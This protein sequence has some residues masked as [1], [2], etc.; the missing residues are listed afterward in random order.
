[1]RRLSASEQSVPCTTT[2]PLSWPAT[3]SLIFVNLYLVLPR[4]CR[5]QVSCHS[6]EGPK[7]T[8]LYTGKRQIIAK[9]GARKKGGF[10]FRVKYAGSSKPEITAAATGTRLWQR[11]RYLQFGFM[12]RKSDLWPVVRRLRGKCRS[13]NCT[14]TCSM[15]PLAAVRPDAV[16][17]ITGPQ[18]YFSLSLFAFAR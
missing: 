12:T 2:T 10:P 14:T 1:M 15:L 4:S 7:S 6:V 18:N 3:I 9:G 5:R 8:T 13:A 17:S 16:R 11:S